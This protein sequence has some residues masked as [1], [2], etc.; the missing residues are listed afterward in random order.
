MLRGIKPTKEQIVFCGIGFFVGRAVCF[1]MNPLAAAFWAALYAGGQCHVFLMLSILLGMLSA[2]S[3]SNAIAFLL[4]AFFFFVAYRPL[5]EKQK[6]ELQDRQ[7]EGL[8]LK[9]SL[10]AGISI[11]AT[12]LFGWT[13]V[14][15]GMDDGMLLGDVGTLKYLWQNQK[16]TIL[17]LLSALLQGVVTGCLTYLF[18]E[19]LSKK[20]WDL[21]RAG[22]F[23]RKIFITG[24]VLLAIILYGLPGSMYATFAIAESVCYFAILVVAYMYGIL[25]S[26]LVAALGG[27]VLAYQLGDFSVL[28]LVTLF[29][30]AAGIFRDMGRIGVF[31][32]MALIALCV[33]FGVDGTSLA[34]NSLKGLVTAGVIFLFLPRSLLQQQ[35][36]EETAVM[37]LMQEQIGRTVREKMRDFAGGFLGLQRGILKL[38]KPATVFSDQD[39]STMYM[40]MKE[41][42]CDQCEGRYRCYNVDPEQ[43]YKAAKSVFLALDEKGGLAKEDIPEEFACVCDNQEAFMVGANVSFER[44][45]SN[46]I[47]K[48]KLSESREM[49]AAQIGDVA[50]QM[51]AFSSELIEDCGRDE[52]MEMLLRLRLKPRYVKVKQV[53]FWKREREPDVLYVVAQCK[54]G[55]LMTAKELSGHVSA[56][57]KKRYCPSDSCKA[58]VT[59]QYE[60]FSFVEEPCFHV[61]KGMKRIALE[62]GKNGD[63]YSFLQLEDGRFVAMLSDGMGTGGRAYQ[64]SAMLIELLEEF[65]EAGFAQEMAIKLANSVMALDMQSQVYATL[66]FFG[67]DLFTGVGR[68][69]KIGASAT[70]LKH[71]EQVDMIVSTSLPAGVFTE[72]EPDAIELSLADGDMVIMVS[73]GVMDAVMAQSKELYLKDCIA[74]ISASNP[75]MMAQELMDKLYEE[76]ISKVK[77]D[78][79]VLAFGIWKRGKG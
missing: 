35:Q 30:L 77:D 27:A 16:M 65:L 52:S 29:G 19:G 68:L 13:V 74:E 70:Y 23:N 79:T 2:R 22:G 7:G 57:Y 38:P 54:V 62:D 10:L 64:A 5:F 9:V 21:I 37:D 59:K 34:S 46:R 41:N 78:M 76:G 72:F 69:V 55:H 45:K 28:G 17:A 63:N 20:E 18:M 26:T 67:V 58:V 31:S 15:G 33:Q 61:T 8:T 73:D 49:L 32:G 1:Q 75:Q 47:I 6:E 44:A 56:V 50:R 66:D 11:I 14:Q 48:E 60:V 4:Y 39:I 25:E 36:V 51:N 71:G 12:Q 42:V 3:F 40:Q 53:L 43:T 24:A